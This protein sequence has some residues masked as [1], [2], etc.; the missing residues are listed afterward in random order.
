MDRND[1]MDTA[2]TTR[3]EEAPVEDDSPEFVSPPFS[4]LFLTTAKVIISAILVIGAIAMLGTTIFLVG[5][6][7]WLLF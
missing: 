3:V 1:K 6:A 4:V 7:V 2:L 5:S